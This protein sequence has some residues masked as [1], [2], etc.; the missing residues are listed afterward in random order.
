MGNGYFTSDSEQEIIE[1]SQILP[2]IFG[3][4]KFNVQQC[5]SNCEA[6][7]SDSGPEVKLLGMNWNKSLDE[8]SNQVMH[9]LADTKRKILRT[10][11]HNWDIFNISLPLMNKARFFMQILQNDRNLSWDQKL[12]ENRLTKWVNI[13]KSFNKIPVIK[14]NRRIGNRADL[15][16][17]VGSCDA[18]GA[19][20][21]MTLH[22]INETSKKIFF[23][24]ARNKLLSNRLRKKSIPALELYSI[25]FALETIIEIINDLT[26]D[27]IVTPMKIDKVFLFS[28]SMVALNW[29]FNYSIKFKNFNSKNSVFVRNKLLTISELTDSQ[30]VY[31]RFIAGKQNPSDLTTREVTYRT[32]SKSSFL[33]GKC[34]SNFGFYNDPLNETSFNL[35]ITGWPLNVVRAFNLSV[36]DWPLGSS[37][38]S[39]VDWPLDDEELNLSPDWPLDVPSP[40]LNLL[41]VSTVN[42][43]LSEQIF[44]VEKYNSFRKLVGVHSFILKFINHIK[45]LYIAKYPN[46]RSRFNILPSNENWFKIAKHLVISRDQRI[47]FKECFDY[48]EK[49]RHRLKDVPN[50]MKQLNIFKEDGCLKVRAKN[51]RGGNSQLCYFPILLHKRSHITKSLIDDIHRKNL[52]CGKYITLREFRKEFWV[53]QIFSLVKGQLRQCVTC[54]KFNAPFIKLNQNSYREFRINPTS[55]PYRCIFIDYIGPY[56]VLING[57]KVKCNILCFTCVW[58][59]AIHFELCR[60]MTTKTFLRA[61]QKHIFKNGLPDEIFADLGSQIGPGVNT[62]KEFLNDVDTKTFLSSQNISGPN[63]SQYYKGNSALGSLV[64][65]LIKIV[66]RLIRSSIGKTILDLEDFEFLVAQAESIMNKRPIA[67]KETLRENNLTSDLPETITPEILIRGCPSVDINV[68]PSLQPELWADD[69]VASVQASFDKLQKCRQKLIDTYNE[70]HLNYLITQATNDKSR[71]AKISHRP[72]KVGDIVLIR[73]PNVKLSNYPMGVVLQVFENS[74]GEVTHVILKKGSTNEKIKRHVS[75]L[76]HLLST[77]DAESAQCATA[78]NIETVDSS[79]NTPSIATANDIPV[80]N[81]TP[82]PDPPLDVATDPP[83]RRVPRRLAARRNAD[84]RARLIQDGL[85]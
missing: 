71:Y 36:V 6:V 27:E 2:E 48:F 69:P 13:A 74:I 30:P 12:D 34:F 52:H 50:I 26:A 15:F 51:L 7:E 1:F 49:D 66:K 10:I 56:L 72:L 61:F 45:T 59:R 5:E 16:S 64:E 55:I 54:S 8:L 37:N 75:Q 80:Q 24:Y 76:K 31:F 63:F 9:P 84:L 73:E 32:Y 11:A 79:G 22:V 65:S 39:A 42:G 17:L 68:I 43:P 19:S 3:K 62:I 85:I 44:P 83:D 67:F 40:T 25:S 20:I 46:K 14:I 60:D 77:N 78:Q 58:S 28:D 21:G 4:Y 70:E 33:S 82:L 29:V 38:L 53:P 18:S 35:P 41:T 81:P 23:L 57:D 47:Y